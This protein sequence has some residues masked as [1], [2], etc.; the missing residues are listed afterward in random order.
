MLA[1]TELFCHAGM[2]VNRPYSKSALI[3]LTHY[4]VNPTH[5][6][7]GVYVLQ[8]PVLSMAQHT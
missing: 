5:A 1:R 8:P 4:A 6:M 2:L 3:D 7:S